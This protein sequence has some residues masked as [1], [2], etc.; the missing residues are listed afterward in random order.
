MG[1]SE[2][3]SKQTDLAAVDRALIAAVQN[4]LPLA[5][6]PY[7]EVGRGLGLTEAGVIARLQHL[8][9]QGVIKRMGV[10][11]RHRELGYHANA[12]VVWDI[13]DNRVDALGA[14]MGQFEFVSLC[15]RRPRRLPD[16]PYNLF[17]MIHGRDHDAVLDNV[18]LLA[19]RCG[20]EQVRREVLFSRR[21]FKQ[22]G[23]RYGAAAICGAEV[24]ADGAGNLRK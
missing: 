23:A 1:V 5:S 17:C 12:M 3:D 10:V 13:P 19:Q 20:L 18:R 24:G 16:W 22:R 4:G 21:R 11:V 9:Q 6:R 14:C 8:R 15:Y 2:T 7:A